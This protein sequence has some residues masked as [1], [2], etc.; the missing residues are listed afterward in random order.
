MPWLFMPRNLAQILRRLA[1]RAPAGR[2]G[3]SFASTCKIPLDRK[4]PQNRSGG[5]RKKC[6][7]VGGF[8]LFPLR[9]TGSE[10]RLGLNPAEV[11]E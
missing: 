11:I 2:P 10:R 5:H 3:D 6:A 8:S 7:G 1:R 4:T 9:L